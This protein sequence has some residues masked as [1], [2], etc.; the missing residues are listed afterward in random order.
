MGASTL[1][2]NSDQT[3]G[4]IKPIKTSQKL[5]LKSLNQKSSIT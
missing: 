5:T 4:N 2:G 3:K 1:K